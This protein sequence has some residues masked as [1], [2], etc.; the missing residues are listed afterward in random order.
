MILK[1]I[2]TAEDEGEKILTILKKRLDCSGT[3]VKRLKS[4][5]TILLNGKK[6]KSNERVKNGDLV[7]I[8]ILEHRDNT[9]IEPTPMPLEI[10][11]EDRYMV[12]VNKPAGIAVHPA[13][14]YQTNTLANGLRHHYLLSG[15]DMTA[16][17]VGRLDRNTSGITI[18]AKNAHVM[19]TMVRA[20]SNEISVKIYLGLVHGIP[21]KKSGLIDLP[22]KRSVSSIIARITSEDGKPSLTR[23]RVLETYNNASLIQY[24]LLT[25]RTHQIRLHT[26]AL[27]F[28]LVGDGIYG[29]DSNTGN[30]IDRHALHCATTRFIHP[31]TKKETLLQAP[32]PSDFIKAIE[33]FKY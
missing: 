15:I 1:H 13:G 16:R 20:L 33:Y 8:K 31:Y 3:M 9:H 17:A 2:I 28:P 30:I 26:S 18:F 7:S 24:E 32:L 11:F 21:Q 23:Y 29:D 6:T 25:G 4:N 19:T 5:N 12:V 27:G 10:I 14:K 22:I